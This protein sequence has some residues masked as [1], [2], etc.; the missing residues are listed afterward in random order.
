MVSIE[1]TNEFHGSRAVA[2]PDA[3]GILSE[4]QVRRIRQTLCGIGTCT[5]GQTELRTRGRQSVE[6]VPLSD[7][8]VQ[9]S[10][11]AS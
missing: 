6:I 7:G 1:L 10:L 4:D 8:R 11:R 9:L 5:C 3:D 2:R